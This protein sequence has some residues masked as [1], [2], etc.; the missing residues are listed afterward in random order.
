MDIE[1]EALRPEGGGRGDEEMAK[2]FKQQQEL[3]TKITSLEEKLEWK[4][5]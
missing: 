1:L 3:L 2:F 4:L 5:F